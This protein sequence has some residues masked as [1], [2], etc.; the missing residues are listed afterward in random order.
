MTRF[1]ILKKLRLIASFAILL[2]AIHWII[3]LLFE[4]KDVFKEALI[5]HVFLFFITSFVFILA[6]KINDSHPT[7]T[8]EV[9]MGA[10][11]VK[12]LLVMAFFIIVYLIKDDNLSFAYSF[13]A[14]YFFYLPFNAVLYL[15]FFKLPEQYK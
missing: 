2:I 1:W 5:I 6:R 15:K 7:Y 8:T 11:V 3:S 14:I 13:L 12:M 10:N 9:M 4:I